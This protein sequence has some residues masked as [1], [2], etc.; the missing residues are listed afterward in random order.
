MSFCRSPSSGVDKNISQTT[1][2]AS[3]TAS[4]AL[5]QL[6]V[7]LDEIKC[8]YSCNKENSSMTAKRPASGG[9]S[10]YLIAPMQIVGQNV[11]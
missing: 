9:E 10:A 1:D 2:E 6:P 11:R 5:A 3:G 8:N 7:A 4:Q